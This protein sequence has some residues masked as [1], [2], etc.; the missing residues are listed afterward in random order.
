MII[1]LNI[2]LILVGYY[3]SN[4]ISKHLI[5]SYKDKISNSGSVKWIFYFFFLQILGA[6]MQIS[7]YV[8]S[9][10][11]LGILSFFVLLIGLF[12]RLRRIIIEK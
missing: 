12:I 11:I 1:L 7:G 2:L 5:V 10:K 9:S 4:V 8:K 6:C 3:L